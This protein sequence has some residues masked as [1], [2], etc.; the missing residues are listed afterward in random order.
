MSG[1]EWFW[2][3][4]LSFELGFG[5]WG[6]ISKNDGYNR[7]KEQHKQRQGDMRQG[8]GFFKDIREKVE[9]MNENRGKPN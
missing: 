4:N 6:G 9:F 7:K 3:E 8:Q 1:Y 2:L 5:G